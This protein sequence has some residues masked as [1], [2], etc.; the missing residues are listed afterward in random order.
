LLK[1]VFRVDDGTVIGVHVRGADACELV[2]LG[3]YLIKNK[4]T[5]FE[6]MGTTFTAVTHH[7]LFKAAAFDGNAKLEFGLQWRSLFGEIPM[8]W[9]QAAEAADPD[10]Y[11]AMFDFIDADGSGELDAAELHACF[12]KMGKPLSRST[13][14]NLVRLSD[15]DG[16]GKID[17]DRF[18]RI[19]KSIKAVGKHRL[20]VLA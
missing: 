17:W 10:E 18:P 4:N 7:E 9:G 2:R 16:S 15:A 14:A 20:P 19:F 12:T 1:L 11:K 8:D 3:M 13:V 5:I 6:I